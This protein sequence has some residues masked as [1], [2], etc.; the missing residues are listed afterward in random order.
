MI[1]HTFK[2][3]AAALS[4]LIAAPAAQAETFVRVGG[5]LAGT[6]PV[7]AAKLAELINE[8]IEGVTANVVSG[9]VEKSQIM[10]E[11]GELDFNI[12]PTFMT[13]QIAEGRG[14][15]GAPTPNVRH[16]ITL[17][18]SPMQP[19][20]RL[21]GPSTLA[22][23]DD[24]PNRVWT[25]QKSGFFYQVFAPMMQAAGVSPE[26]IEAA[27]GVIEQYGYLEEV[28]GF[29]DGNLD[30][31]IFAGPV[32]YGLMQQFEQTPGFQLIG[33]S[34]AELDAFEEILPGMTRFTIP[35]GSYANN[36]DDVEVPFYVNHLVASAGADPELVYQVTKLM[37]ENYEAF[38]GLFAGSEEIDDQDVFAHNNLSV[39]E[40]SQRFF[41]EV[42]AQ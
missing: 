25:G 3:G 30:A 40:A 5:G 27:G 35:G 13:Y 36:P 42:G 15:L 41:D 31:G 8:N 34:E 39:H 23:L 18:G 33:M 1:S 7:F 26:S 32:P 20:A 19:V 10:I 38:H 11:T 9:D 24:A 21:G 4:L 14:S 28:Q 6:F 12:A 2:A 16:V 29:Q 37:Y 17:Y 22:E